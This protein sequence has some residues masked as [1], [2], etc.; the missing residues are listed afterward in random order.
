MRYVRIFSLNL[1]QALDHRGRSFV[2]FLIA[3]FNSLFYLFVF[4]LPLTLV[5]TTPA[6]VLLQRLDITT[7]LIFFGLAALLVTLSR[8]F[9]KFALRYYTSANG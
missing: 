8:K 5:I 9:W 4:L 2:W 6:K 1:E 7:L 3:F